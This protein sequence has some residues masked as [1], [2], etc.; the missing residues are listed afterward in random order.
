MTKVY[1]IEFPDQGCEGLVRIT[2]PGSP[3]WH[4]I[5][6]A[7][8]WLDPDAR[9]NPVAAFVDGLIPQHACVLFGTVGAGEG[10]L[11][12]LEHHEDFEFVHNEW[13]KG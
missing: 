12:I 5:R 7:S 10:K 6:G 3:A 13:S 9:T 4:E 8:W 2:R 1:Y 11:A